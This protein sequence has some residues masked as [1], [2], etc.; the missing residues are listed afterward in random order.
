[1][2]LADCEKK[3]VG[4][5]ANPKTVNEWLIN[6]NGYQFDSYLVWDSFHQFG[7]HYVGKTSSHSEIRNYFNAGHIVILNVNNG[8][9]WVL[10]NG[11]VTSPQLYLVNDPGHPQG[12]YDFDEIVS[13]VVYTRPS[14]C[15]S[16][17]INSNFK[18]LPLLDV[19]IPT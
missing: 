5:P 15:L 16:R 6:N 7:M 12:T 13:A 3:I 8:G 4:Q 2:V 18:E 11:F 9:H 17:I 10:L 14:S 19:S 1:M